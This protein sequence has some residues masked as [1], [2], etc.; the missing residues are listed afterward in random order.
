MM[1]V[2]EFLELCLIFGVPLNGGGGG[3]VPTTEN[4]TLW[5]DANDP[6]GDGTQPA[7]DTV[8]PVW[9]D[10]SG[11]SNNVLFNQDTGGPNFFKNIINSLPAMLN[12]GRSGVQQFY[13]L[14]N[15]LNLSSTGGMSV[16]IVYQVFS[17]YVNN[18][19]LITMG[20]TSSNALEIIPSAAAGAGRKFSLISNS[21]AGSVN[22]QNGGAPALGV[23][24]VDT[25]IYGGLAPTGILRINGANASVTL[26]DTGGRVYPSDL[27]FTPNNYIGKSLTG[28][29][30][31]LTAYIGEILI[32]N[33]EHTLA[34]AEKIENYLIAKW[35]AASSND[36][37]N[38]NGSGNSAWQNVA[39]YAG[40]VGACAPMC[41]VARLDYPYFVQVYGNV[42]TATYA[43]IGKYNGTG[44]VPTY[45]TSVLLDSTLSGNQLSYEIFN[46]AGADSSSAVFVNYYHG[47]SGVSGNSY[48]RLITRSGMAVVLNPVLTI[49]AGNN[50]TPNFPNRA[51]D[52]LIPNVAVATWWYD[53]GFNQPFAAI[54]SIDIIALTLTLHTP[55]PIAVSSVLTTVG[56]GA[57]CCLQGASPK[58]LMSYFDTID[59]PLYYHIVSATVDLGTY[60]ITIVNDVPLTITPQEQGII[61]LAM[62]SGAAIA[63]LGAA[64]S[65]NSLS[66]LSG[67]EIDVDDSA[68]IT[69]TTQQNLV[70]FGS[71]SVLSG[72]TLITIPNS[73]NQ[74]LVAYGWYNPQNGAFTSQALACVTW[75]G[76]GMTPLS[77]G[78]PVYVVP[79]SAQFTS[80]NGD[81]L[82]EDTLMFPIVQY[83]L[84][85]AGLK[86]LEYTNTIVSPILYEVLE[87]DATNGDTYTAINS[88]SYGLASGT[89]S[90]STVTVA[91]VDVT[92]LIP[93]TTNILLGA[94]TYQ[95][96]S[97]TF[98]GGNTVITT[99]QSLSNNYTAVNLY[100]QILPVITD[101]VN[102]YQFIAANAATS[103]M[104]GFV[105]S[106]AT[107]VNYYNGT[108]FSSVV[109]TGIAWALNVESTLFIVVGNVFQSGIFLNDIYTNTNIA[110][111]GNITATNAQTSAP[112][113]TAD[114]QVGTLSFTANLTLITLVRKIT[115]SEV[116]INGVL[117]ATGNNVAQTVMGEIINMVLGNPWG[118]A[119]PYVNLW[120][121]AMG[122]TQRGDIETAIIAKFGI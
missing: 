14:S 120:N 115:G 10:K 92:Q 20:T 32:Y 49:S 60:D 82:N 19:P 42:T 45:G 116:Y 72:N 2:D 16:Y 103:P 79:G 63:I 75:S 51:S 85:N 57:L 78:D 86:F 96:A 52:I 24:T 68:A 84:T 55:V 121:G 70:T 114:W 25:F 61:L 77:I 113:N 1:S 108:A 95:L 40:Q 80:S 62:N 106:Q 47:G 97:S 31:N 6:L 88:P 87:L 43:V 34:E 26:T 56:N 59:R 9:Y 89:I 17:A 112:G 36:W 11:N 41:A 73:L 100:T 71:D 69:F 3:S 64:N 91:G 104:L 21:A 7:T 83:D 38:W 98:T 46:V 50:I 53:T 8:V 18:A 101:T 39:V 54:I 99:V 74:F 66:Y 110:S 67:V 28:G 109:S 44:V 76:S 118:G 35:E 15:N 5:L 65:D 27:Q 90:T 4:M 119:C 94:S 48:A 81:Y 12:D 22:F 33:T 23:A 37:R 93:P 122:D 58:I 111:Q 30:E 29:V 107:F 117:N 105:N 102:G 13:T